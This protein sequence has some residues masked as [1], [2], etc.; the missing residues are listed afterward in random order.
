MIFQNLTYSSFNSPKGSCEQCKG[1]GSI[2][3]VNV[4]SIIPDDDKSIKN[5]GILPLKLEHSSH[6]YQQIN[7]ICL[8]YNFDLSTPIKQIPEDG[9]NALLYGKKE[10]FSQ[11]I[12]DLGFTREYEI[13]FDGVCNLMLSYTP[14][15]TST[16]A[17]K[18]AMEYINKV[19]CK[20]CNGS[21]LNNKSLYFK[22][23]HKNIAE[24]TNLDT[25]ELYKFISEIGLHLTKKQHQIAY[26]ILK[27]LKV[28]IQFLLDIGLDYLSLNRGSSTLSGGEAQR[29]RLASQIGSKLTGVLYI[30]DEPSIG[31]HQR[32]NTKLIAS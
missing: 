17:K 32:D 19:A 3:Q 6:T 29:I 16:S 13:D 31:L 20:K 27:E 23:N 30:L 10:K 8:R 7:R 28:R 26:D 18:W 22:I 24:I 9:L 4:S 25:H 21:R 11:Y 12:K 15:N 2:N 5:G 1:I 14:E